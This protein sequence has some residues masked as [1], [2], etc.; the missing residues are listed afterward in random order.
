M[1][2][3]LTLV[4]AL[5]F[6]GSSAGVNAQGTMPAAAGTKPAAKSEEKMET[7]KEEAM[8]NGKS[9]KSMKHQGK[10]HHGKRAPKSK[11]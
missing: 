1:K 9:S 5:A 3:T 6:I 10:M 11:M 8:E 7:K 4:A 2:T